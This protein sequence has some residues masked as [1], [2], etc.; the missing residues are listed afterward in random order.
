M[1]EQRSPALRILRPGIAD[2]QDAATG[3]LSIVGVIQVADGQVCYRTAAKDIVFC[4]PEAAAG[5]EEDLGR[6]VIMQLADGALLCTRKGLEHFHMTQH[7][8]RNRDDCIIAPRLE[9]TGARLVM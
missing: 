7:R 8:K 5:L 4:F 6:S 1:R 9:T 2:Q 3:F